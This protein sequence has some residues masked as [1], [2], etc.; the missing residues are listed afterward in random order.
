MYVVG[1]GGIGPPVLFREPVLRTGRGTTRMS[2]T[3]NN[4]TDG[5][6]RTPRSQALDLLRLPVSPRRHSGPDRANPHA[7]RGNIHG[8]GRRQNLPPRKQHRLKAA[9]R[10]ARARIIATQLSIF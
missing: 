1:D 6:T 8:A 4:G 7:S 9:S 10:P 2:P 3:L 5:E